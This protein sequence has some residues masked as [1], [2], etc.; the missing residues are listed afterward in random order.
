MNK[1]KNLFIAIIVG[2]LAILF[3]P[4]SYEVKAAGDV[5][6][7]YSAHVE[8]IGDQ[9]AVYDGQ[10][11]GTTGRNLQIE[12]ISINLEDQVGSMSIRY[13]THVE[14]IG[15]GQWVT[16]GQYSGTRGKEL[17]V[18]AI[19][20]QLVNAPANYHIE[21][22]THVQDIGW[23]NWVRD[24]DIA[25]TTGRNKR[26]EAIRLRIVNDNEIK[27][28]NASVQ[29]QSSVQGI[30]TQEVVSDAGIAGTIGENLRLENISIA[31]G[32]SPSGASISYRVHIEN[33]GWLDW[34][35]AGIATG[36]IGND[37]RVE[38]IQIKING[39]PEGYHVEYKAHVQDIG[40][41]GWVRD[42][43]IAGTTGQSKKIEAL[44]I[45]IV[46]D[47]IN[48]KY[49]STVQ[50][51]GVQAAVYNG[52][53][54]GTVGQG[55]RLENINIAL[56]GVNSNSGVSYRVHLENKGWLDW[57]SNGITTGAIDNNKRIEAIQIRLQNIPEG[58]HVEYRAHV[59]DI[60]WQDWVRDGAVAG[61]T[62]QSKKIEG[63][64]VRV[65]Q[66]IV[67]STISYV[68]SNYSISFEDILNK[69]I[70]K[71]P[72][73]QMINNSNSWEWRYAQIRD[74]Q[75]GYYI[76]PPTKI[77][78]GDSNVYNTIKDQ[79]QLNLDTRLSRNYDL[80]KYQFLKLSYID[81][82]TAEQ[83]NSSF[84]KDGV[85]AGKGQVFIDAARLYNIN[86]IYL[87]AHSMLETG[88]GTSQL[89]K[90]ISVNG[91][92]VYNLFGIGAVDSDPNGGGSQTAYTK[93]W[94][95][96]DKAIYGGAEFISS[97]YINS[98]YKQDTLYKMRWNPANPGTHQYATDIR[99]ATN[100]VAYIKKCF[101]QIPDAKL[102][103][104]IPVYK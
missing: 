75:A 54:S 28:N 22:Q 95:S 24:G 85:L 58:Y 23:Q 17:Q 67:S 51:R 3:L 40:W 89:A 63:I 100:Q 35:P 102:V 26:V 14:N 84:S 10:V 90:G 87:A 73:L 25:G 33:R 103:F 5:S 88:N 38:G 60:G 66:D 41:Q 80:N 11:I 42:G 36:A 34:V 53:T 64:Q 68:Y 93:G 19:Q 97:S 6:L 77:F 70:S 61:T 21:Y 59:Q 55:L 44:K 86:P 101:D 50:D 57:V 96:I 56:E 74:G 13:R 29:Y 76:N 91:T 1:N 99:W 15:W 16:G 37:R 83:L 49:Q 4:T 52:E 104:D 72:A 71:E 20:I 18:E 2:F 82:T 45:R 78:F 98:S 47:K 46:S 81:G 31:L 8:N 79:L 39:F 43:E 7:K 32:N 62:G 30:G 92:T 27:P 94:T 69:Q 48:V 9:K 65:V 12:G